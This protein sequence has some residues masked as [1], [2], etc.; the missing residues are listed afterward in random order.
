MTVEDII[1]LYLD[2]A[3]TV[4]P[5]YLKEEFEETLLQDFGLKLDDEIEKVEESSK[6]T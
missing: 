4:Q 3:S 1:C 6:D 2:I 5:L